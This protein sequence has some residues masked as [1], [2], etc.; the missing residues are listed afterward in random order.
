MLLFQA[1]KDLIPPPVIISFD[2]VTLF[3]H[4]PNAPTLQFIGELLMAA[5]VP[6]QEITE[7]F[8]LLDTS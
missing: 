7:I 6:Y 2:V 5:Q 4:S 1:V 3:P 8:E